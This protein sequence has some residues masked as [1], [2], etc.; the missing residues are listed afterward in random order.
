[1]KMKDYKKLLKVVEFSQNDP[2]DDQVD[3]LQLNNSSLNQLPSSTSSPKSTS[4]APNQ[5]MNQG[6]V[7]EDILLE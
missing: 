1:M 6:R 2:A 5:L 3:Y 4:R 7:S